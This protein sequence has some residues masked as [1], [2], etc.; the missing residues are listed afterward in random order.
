MASTAMTAMRVEVSDDRADRR[1]SKLPCRKVSDQ[2]RT[3]LGAI[4]DVYAMESGFPMWVTV[5]TKAGI[6]HGPPVFV[7]L[8]RL[9][10]ENGEQQGTH[11][12]IA[13]G[14]C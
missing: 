10:E 4:T 7:P 11:P 14:R 13:R 5:Q 3:E 8:A 1:R 12:R 9:K 2:A 6:G